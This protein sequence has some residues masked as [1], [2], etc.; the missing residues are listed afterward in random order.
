[1]TKSCTP[2]SLLALALGAALA[3]I[4]TPAAAEENWNKKFGTIEDALKDHGL[5]APPKLATPNAEPHR[6]R[7]P[8]VTVTW[9]GTPPVHRKPAGA[10]GLK[11]L[12]SK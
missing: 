3:A 4:A 9:G 12:K 11:S 8:M 6:S 10:V 5:P 1:M 2:S 7:P